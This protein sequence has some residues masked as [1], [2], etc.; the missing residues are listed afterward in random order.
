MS[1]QNTRPLQVLWQI[2]IEKEML[3]GVFSGIKRVLSLAGVANEIKVEHLGQRRQPDWRN[4][5]RTSL[6]PYQSLDWHLKEARLNRKKMGYL[7]SSVLLN[8]LVDHPTYKTEPRYELV[9]VKEPLHSTGDPPKTIGGAALQEKSAVL[10]LDG[11]LNLLQPKAGEKDENRKKRQAY[12][13]LAT[14]ML[15]IHELCHIFK[16][17]SGI[18]PVNQTDEEIKKVHCANK[19][20][21]CWEVNVWMQIADQPLCPSCLETLPKFFLA[22]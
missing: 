17:F 2:G 19:C 3:A 16:L 7:N 9:V 21:M 11:Y 12:F 8:T 6:S 13:F 22:P 10:T 1:F 18:S 5:E 20:V 4:Q 15:T 14:E